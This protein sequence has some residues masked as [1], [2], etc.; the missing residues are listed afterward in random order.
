MT[1][2]R[3]GLIVDIL[4]Y[5]L[6]LAQMLYIFIG[7]VAHEIIG[8]AFFVCMV[9]HLVLKGWWFRTL[10]KKK[11]ASRRFFDVLTCLLILTVLTLMFSSMGVS[12]ILF[13][14]FHALG[15]ADLHRYLATA[16]LAMGVLHGGMHG[17]WRA[18]KKGRALVLVILA[19]ILALALGLFGVPYMNRH[20]KQVDISHAD[21]V[22]GDKVDWKGKKPLVVYFTRLGNTDFEPDVDAV[23]GASLLMSDGEMMGSNQLLADM[24]CDILD[25][26]AAAITLTGQ[27]YP[28][29]YNSTI[30]VARDELKA[31][32]R[33]AIE[34][35]DVSEYDSLILIYPLWW[36]SIPMPVATFLEQHDLREKIIYLIA[37]QGSAGYGSTV[38]EIEELAS[39]AK[40]VKGT[41]I[42]CEDIP[43]ARAELYELIRSWNEGK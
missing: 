16:V 38:S 13:P 5:G 27:R 19:T 9:V 25:C 39:G 24:I 35:I 15:S 20:L 42:Y 21:K 1:K 26:D 8:I 32:A 41:S 37:T 17:I 10:F 29:S 34:T 18:K 28:S 2:K 3:V 36:G 30:S 23:S 22:Q 33:P 14:W 4:M 7:G 43:D 6:L 11:S 40:V 31:N 12:R